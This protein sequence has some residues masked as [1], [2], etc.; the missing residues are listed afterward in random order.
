[1]ARVGV[2]IEVREDY[3]PPG[4][5]AT[6]A[7]SMERNRR[8]RS[9]CICFTVWLSV[10]SHSRQSKSLMVM[11][12]LLQSLVRDEQAVRGVEHPAPAALVDALLGKPARAME[13][14]V[15]REGA[16]RVAARRRSNSAIMPS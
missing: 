5:A 12:G 14:E 10:S 1:M 11:P 2:G 6:R 9:A 3:K 4:R 16:A 7:A 13:V 15:Q 8:S